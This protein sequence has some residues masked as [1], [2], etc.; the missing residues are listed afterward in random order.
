MDGRYGLTAAMALLVTGLLPASAADLTSARVT[1]TVNQV[2]ISNARGGNVRAAKSGTTFRIPELLRTGPASR[3]ELVSPDKT[4]TRVGS[5]TVFSFKQ[6]KRGINLQQGCVL[7]HSPS[8]QGGGEIQTVAASAGV[9]GTTIIVSATRDG[10][11]KLLVMEGNGYVTLGGRRSRIPAGHLT[12]ITPGSN[13]LETYEYRLSAQVRGAALLQGFNNSGG[14]VQ[15]FMNEIKK[16][17]AIQEEEIEEG[18]KEDTGLLVS[19]YRQQ[20]RLREWDTRIV[21][22]NSRSAF[23]EAMMMRETSSSSSYPYSTSF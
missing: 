18:E 21:D 13:R 20:M 5:N 3:A 23:F 8:G 4:V 9:T 10:G 19:E 7:F 11:F 15:P 14:A 22:Q 16:Q 1:Q 6:G 17:V 2:K 12:F